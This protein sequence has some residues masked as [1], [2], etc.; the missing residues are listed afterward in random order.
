MSKDGV[1]G[2]LAS[3]AEAQKSIENEDLVVFL[4]VGTT[5]IARPED[6]PVYV[7][8]LLAFPLAVSL[9]C[10]RLGCRSRMCG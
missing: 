2:W 10:L 5:H 4:S 6:W 7:L 3:D 8:F 1:A 9:M